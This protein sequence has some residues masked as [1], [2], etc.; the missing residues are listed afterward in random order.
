MP[1]EASPFTATALAL[2]GLRNYASGGLSDVVKD[3]ARQARSWL[4][5][6]KPV[7]TEDRVFRVWGRQIRSECQKANRGANRKAI[8]TD[9]R[10]YYPLHSGH[11][12]HLNCTLCAHGTSG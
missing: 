2:R 6:N 9:V 10:A 12:R 4:L 1:I 3:R 8:A 11:F 5:R 7:D